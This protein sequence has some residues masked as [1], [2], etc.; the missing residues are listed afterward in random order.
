MA[1]SSSTAGKL[2]R[3]PGAFRSRPACGFTLIELLVVIAIIAILAAMLLPAL[4]RAKEK[5]QQTSCLNNT[6]QLTLAWTMYSGDFQDRLVDNHTAGNADCGPHAWITSGTKLG[7][8]S[9]SGNA[10]VDTNNW[11]I[12]NGLLYPFNANYQIYHCP[13]DRSTVNA[14]PGVLRSR[15]YSMSVGMNWTDSSD[16]DPSNG[17]FIKLGAIVN[18]GPS[19]AVVFLDEAANSIDN[20]ALGIFSGTD[21]D[22]GG[23]SIGY[24]NLPASR[25]SRGCTLSFADAHS[26]HWKWIDAWIVQDNAIPDSYSGGIMGPGW[27][28]PSDAND[29]DLKRLKQTVPVMH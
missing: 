20:N 17:S 11:A 8:G 6:K 4:S 18:P 5:A 29:R 25:H 10:R 12:V 7:V 23:G 15:S 27:G 2:R 22:P 26:E 9:W 13:S 24:W 1:R 14:R 16:A 3:D 21:A 19:K 28:A